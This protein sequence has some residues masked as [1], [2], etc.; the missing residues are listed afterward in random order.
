MNGP[1]FIYLQ[2]LP[3]FQRWVFSSSDTWLA[4][5]LPNVSSEAQDRDFNLFLKI[6]LC[7]HSATLTPLPSFTGICTL[8]NISG[9]VGRK[10]LLMYRSYIV[11]YQWP[12]R[13]QIVRRQGQLW[14]TLSSIVGHFLNQC[15]EYNFKS[16]V[17]I[18]FFCKLDHKEETR[19]QIPNT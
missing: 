13:C 6:N 11:H 4:T 2:N 16:S 10:V 19:N 1:L 8:A 7:V 15:K 5:A 14:S 12:N 17:R 9:T 18:V 3:C